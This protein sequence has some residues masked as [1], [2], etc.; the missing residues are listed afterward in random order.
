MDTEAVTPYSPTTVYGQ[1]SS[2][3]LVK[4]VSINAH[5]SDEAVVDDVQTFSRDYFTD[6]S[7]RFK[8]AASY[9]PS[10][11]ASIQN[12]GGI[13]SFSASSGSGDIVKTALN[14]GYSANEAITISNA[15]AAYSRSAVGTRNPVGVLRG[16][17]YNIS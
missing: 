6:G 7:A 16:C 8:Y 4:S 15:K 9:S 3:F 12:A 17:K 10:S 14:S 11:I 13:H 2:P 5:T 1:L